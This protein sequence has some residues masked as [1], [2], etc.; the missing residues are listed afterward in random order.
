M[1]YFGIKL[2][3]GMEETVEL[4]FNTVLLKIKKF[5]GKMVNAKNIINII[6]WLQRHGFIV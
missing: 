5:F 3:Q 1:K 4:N 6:K 2:C